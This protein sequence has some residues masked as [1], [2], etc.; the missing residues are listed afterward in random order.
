MV[1][2]RRAAVLVTLLAVVGCTADLR[3]GVYG[4]ADGR[5]PSGMVCR[6]DQLCYA[7]DAPLAALYEPCG[8]NGDCA[9]DSCFKYPFS[10]ETQG[11]CSK[12]CV[13]DAACG[14][15]GVCSPN[16]GCLPS[17]ITDADCDG[18]LGYR[19]LVLPGPMLKKACVHLDDDAR[20]DGRTSCSPPPV[21]SACIQ[22]V[23]CLAITAW[24]GANGV[25]SWPC[26]PDS[27]CP[28]TDVCVSLQQ[29]GGG[30]PTPTCLRPC[31]QKSDCG[32]GMLACVPRS[33]GGNV[34][35]PAGWMG[36]L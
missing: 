18:G 28:G 24:D 19:C 32:T 2:A 23:G 12:S 17:C 1:K 26:T 13:D 27:G 21:A 3:D 25:C 30:L 6:A 33:G 8:G 11:S 36:H 20:L 4:C 29:P 10:S 22:P 5:C 7:A 16:L 31:A 15:G 9:S 34:C 14:A 35:A